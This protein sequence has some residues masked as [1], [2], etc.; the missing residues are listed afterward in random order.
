MRTRVVSAAVIALLVLVASLEADEAPR[1]VV[2]VANPAGSLSRQQAAE[3]F[4]KKETHWPEGT[5]VVPVDQSANSQVRAA[6]CR[7]V[8]GES[9]P[10]VQAY[11]QRQ[12]FSGREVPPVVKS[13]DR[14]V[15]AFVQANRGA[16]GYV[17]DAAALPPDVKVLR[18]EE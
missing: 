10:S 7:A 15:I 4:L 13:S 3:Y 8:L 17:S 2:N 1:L 12:I 16:L 18:L 9:I 14:D 11:W 5:S 6:F